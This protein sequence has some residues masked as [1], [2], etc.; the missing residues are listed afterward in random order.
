MSC[1][2][3]IKIEMYILH[4]QGDLRYMDEITKQVDFLGKFG[5]NTSDDLNIRKD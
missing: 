1:L 5:S 2:K 4:L 3:E